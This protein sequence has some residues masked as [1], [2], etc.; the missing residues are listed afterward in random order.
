MEWNRNIWRTTRQLSCMTHWRRVGEFGNLI[1]V[2]CHTSY[3][4]HSFNPRP[5]DVLSISLAPRILFGCMAVSGKF[6]TYRQ[7]INGNVSRPPF[8]IKDCM[9]N[10]GGGGVITT[11]APGTGNYYPD[12]V[13]TDTCVNDGNEPDYMSTNPEVW[14]H[15]TLESCCS[16]NYLWDYDN[17]IGGGG[18]G[19]VA[20]T[21]VPPSAGLYYP[22]WENTDICLNDGNEPAY[23]SSNPTAWMLDTLFAC[24]WVALIRCSNPLWSIITC[25]DSLTINPIILVQSIIVGNRMNAWVATEQARQGNGL[26]TGVHV[27]FCDLLAW[28]HSLNRPPLLTLI[29]FWYFS[30][31]HTGPTWNSCQLLGYFTQQRTRLLR[32]NGAME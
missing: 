6:A 5:T 16:R 22:D 9:L 14:M 27:S 26:L 19:V 25:I 12:W 15:S 4:M 28:F 21:A 18:G 10:S 1:P 3:H 13:T 32:C 24:W 31:L 20:T 2:F 7:I 30:Y 17:C 8:L 11:I 29:L 23:M